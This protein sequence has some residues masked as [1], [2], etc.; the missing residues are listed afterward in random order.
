[1][2]VRDYRLAPRRV[3]DAGFDVLELHCARGYLLHAFL[4]PLVNGRSDEY[5]G[6]PEN[7]M[8]LPLRIAE[9]VRDEW[10]DSRPM[11][12]RISAVDG[13]GIVWSIEDSIVLCKALAAGGIDAI[14][15]S[16]GGVKLPCGK[17]LISREPGSQVP[18]SARI[19]ADA[20]I[21]TIAVGP[22]R[23]PQ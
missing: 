4:P 11:F 21:L 17:A 10:P 2:L 18:F 20:G 8:R 19:R 23:D 9:V 3:R 12:V 16:S 15:C 7:R 1:M 22:I 5:G 6:S 14:A 13:V